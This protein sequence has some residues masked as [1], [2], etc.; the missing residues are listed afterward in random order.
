[1]LTMND[2]FGTEGIIQNGALYVSEKHIVEVG[3]YK[4][5]KALYPTATVIG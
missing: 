1:M 3:S 4:E 5:I 2:R